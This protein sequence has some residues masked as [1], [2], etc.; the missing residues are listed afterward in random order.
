M[1]KPG[2]TY[3]L[4]L[5]LLGAVLS[6][7]MPP[8]LARAD[9]GEH[10]LMNTGSYT[11]NGTDDRS[12]TGVGFQPDVVIIKGNATWREGVIATDTMP[13]Y[14]KEVR[15]PNT[16]AN[17]R[18]KSLDSD[19]FTL[20]NNENVN[21]NGTSY[22]WVAFKAA[23]G[24]MKT[25]SYTGDGAA[26]QNITDVGFQP[27]FV[28]VMSENSNHRSLYRSSQM[29]NSHDFLANFVSDC[30][31]S[32]LS[33]GF[34]V[35]SD[36]KVNASATTYYY[37]AWNEV[38]G[39]M[40]EDTYTGDG[41]DERSITGV[42]FQPDWVIVQRNADAYSS[43]HKPASTGASTDTTCEWLHANHTNMI[44]ALETDGFQVGTDAGVNTN[45][46]AYCYMAFN[47]MTW[48]SYSSRNGFPAG[49]TQSDS[50]S[51]STNHVYMR[52]EGFSSN[53]T[54][55]V[56]Y[57]D[58][59]GNHK[60]TDTFTGGVTGGILDDSECL[61]TDYASDTAAEGTWHAVVLQQTDALPATY[62]G[63]TGDA[64]YIVDD[65]FS[66]DSS[67]IPEFPT[68]MA[69]IVVTGICFGIYWWMRHRRLAYVKA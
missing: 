64:D 58:G 37:I 45:G 44:Q 15:D 59:D 50:F 46:I 13:G 18:I 51:G 22:Y 4:A 7:F 61:L 6:A 49:W 11:G 41:N 31:D 1:S 26:S 62:A 60:E 5:I 43:Y 65:D 56:G 48:D 30:I 27:E 34:R 63:A 3:I 16:F 52:G 38:T 9:P 25:G 20:G 33:N 14:S 8:Q 29:S 12:I 69:A 19:G 32:M 53:Q 57:Y 40:T 39:R 68:V 55:K 66:V 35:G 36:T 28:I 10:M 42:G 17:D 24:E 67:A 54:L 2:L 21:E 23:A 47:D